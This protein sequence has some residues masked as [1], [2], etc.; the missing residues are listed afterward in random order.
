MLSPALPHRRRGRLPA[1][2][3]LLLALATLLLALPAKT[4]AQGTD[5]GWQ[6]RLRT[7]I[8]RLDA[9]TPG[10][11]GVYVKRLDN[12][13]AYGHGADRR[14]Y[15]GST[16]KV[17]VAIAVLQQ[18]DAGRLKLDAQVALQ[19]SDRI[20][21][22]KLVWEKTGTRHRVD[23]LI[24]RMLRD[25]D[26]TAAN[27]LIR[28]LG[29]EGPLNDSAAAA[30]GKAHMGE[31]TDFARVRRD[32][33][34]E[35]HPDAR[36]LTNPQLVQV[37]AAPIGPQRVTALQR[38]LNVPASALTLRDFDEAYARYYRHD[39]NS[40]T[41]EGYGAM[42]E[43]LVRGEL[44]KP[45]SLQRLNDGMKLGIY[46]NY[47]L[48]AGLPRGVDFIHK[49]GTQHRRACH[50]GVIRPKDGGA[51]GIVV[52]ACTADLD[53]QKAAGP[54]LQRVGQA[55]TQALLQPAQTA[56]R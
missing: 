51:Q 49:T 50:A 54:V 8:E 36:K 7:Q 21:V 45:A 44:L 28:T 43:K 18:V 22:G 46:T 11:L 40:A 55:V 24:Q 15:L 1:P 13:E 23:A 26:N 35:L 42:L 19:D 5:E 31:L 17:L 30:I 33:Y 6:A 39:N 52:V 29:G 20:D 32:V 10:E 53:E 34:A 41:L 2:A 37:A 16:T 12:G 56:A 9:D 48:Q 3:A 47:R 38:V 25:S 14:W 27:M 4:E